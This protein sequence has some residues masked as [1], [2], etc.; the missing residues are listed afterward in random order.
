MIEKLNEITLENLPTLIEQIE[1]EM[2]KQK[3]VRTKEEKEVETRRVCE[4]FFSWR[5]FEENDYVCRRISAI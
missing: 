1:S 4:R 5:F 3:R 2:N